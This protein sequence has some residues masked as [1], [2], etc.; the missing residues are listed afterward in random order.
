[1]YQ[2]FSQLPGNSKIWIYNA[3]RHLN[4]Q[5]QETIM[6][7]AQK[8]CMQWKAHGK[9]L[10]SSAKLFYNQFLVV[11][12]D[13]S[14]NP[15]SGC[16]IDE[17]VYFIKELADILHI[18]LLNRDIVTFLDKETG[19]SISYSLKEAK[20][21]ARNGELSPEQLVFNN[22][23]LNKISL[24]K[25]WIVPVKESWLKNSLPKKTTL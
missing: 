22:F 4:E 10:N 15:I 24:D 20:E 17:S 1:M 25:N 21:K 7:A 14:M 8:F 9:P 12:V 19:N 3:G 5:E 18:D 16:S 6:S 11:G 2:E 13:E 23:V